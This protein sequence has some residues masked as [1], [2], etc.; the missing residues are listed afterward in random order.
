MPDKS[1]VQTNTAPDGRKTEAR[2]FEGGELSRATRITGPKSEPMVLVEFR[3]GRSAVL[4]DP[5]DVTRVLEASEDEIAAAANKVLAS[6]VLSQQ[7][8][9][10]VTTAKPVAET[11]GGNKK[12]ESP[13]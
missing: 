4:K 8:G 3:D 10:A 11:P 13:K 1:T 9:P 12:R 5:N 7:P 2:V 6:G